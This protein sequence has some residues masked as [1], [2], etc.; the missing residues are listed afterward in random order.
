MPQITFIS[1]RDSIYQ[2]QRDSMDA[3]VH[4]HY[5]TLNHRL[6]LEGGIDLIDGSNTSAYGLESFQKSVQ[7]VSGQFAIS[8]TLLGCMLMLAIVKFRQPVKF[9]FLT[10][11]FYKG[12]SIIQ[13]FQDG[14]IISSASAILMTVN[15]FVMLGLLGYYSV[16]E[17][18]VP[19]IAKSHWMGG[20]EM[21]GLIILLVAASYLIKLMFVAVSKL[22]IGA[23]R[24]ITEYRYNILFYVQHM[25]LVLLPIVLTLTFVDQSSKEIVLYFTYGILLLLYLFRLLKTILIG[26]RETVPLLYLFLYLCTLEFLP[27]VVIIKLLIGEKSGLD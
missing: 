26:V 2:V 9:Q 20:A 21:A 24:G 7:P 1:N 23:D 6:E 27:L 10:T 8:L 22:I 13:P 12:S 25:G 17:F 16:V 4:Q 5:E 11:S 3:I 15:S 14:L 19:L 18:S